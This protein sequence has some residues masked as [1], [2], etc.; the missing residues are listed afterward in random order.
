MSHTTAEPRGVDAHNPSGKTFFGHPRMLANLFS[1]EMWERFSFYGMQAI[2]VYYLYHSAA[3][4]GLG[5]DKGAATGI[6]GAYGGM[7]YLMAIVGGY[8]G[9]KILGPERTLFYSAIAIMFGHIALALLPGLAGVVVGLVLIAVGSGCLKTNASV[10]VGSLYDLKDT[11]RDAG[12]TIFYLGVNIGALVGPLL[13]NWLWGLAGFHFGFGLAAIGMFAGLVQYVATRK[14]LPAEA[15]VVPTPASAK[16]KGLAGGAVVVFLLLVALISATGLLTPDNIDNWVIGLT[17]VG[18]I[19]L[20]AVLLTSKHTTADE[21]SRVLSF[22]PLWLANVVFW[23]LFQQQFTVMAVYSD[24]RLDWHLFGMELK[25]GLVNSINP[26]FIIA[27]G[28]LFSVMWTKLGERQPTT[29]TK[30]SFGL[31]GA[32]IAFLIFLT[33][34]GKPVVSL[35][36]IV[37]ILFVLTLSELSISPTGSSLATKLAPEA[38]KSQMMALFWTSVAMGTTLSGWLAGFYSM[39]TEIPYFTTMGLMSIAA[40][41]LVFFGRKPILK[42]MR[43]VR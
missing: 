25:P 23:A 15:R 43:G 14:R 29:V 30:W 8:L 26:I 28:T 6:I 34:A 32:G 33:Q 37:L 38:H 22:V 36:W 5:L 24:T 16:E 35:W 41:L 1:V 21:H 39:D 12:F 3:E 2:L 31:V 18:A 13:T 20:F 4:G 19:A 10:L 7:V 11:R 9:D 17:L 40:G 42:L 27:F